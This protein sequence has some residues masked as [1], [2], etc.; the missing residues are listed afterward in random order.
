MRKTLSFLSWNARGVWANHAA[1]TT[2]LAELISCRPSLVALQETKLQSITPLPRPKCFSHRSLSSCVMRNATRAVGGILSAWDSS[3]CALVK[4]H[5]LLHT[6]TTTFRLAAEDSLSLSLFGAGY[7]F[8]CL[9][10]S[11]SY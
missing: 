6:L 7:F 8:I 9:K 4:T 2:V 5:A 10:N 11:D 1:V 3:V